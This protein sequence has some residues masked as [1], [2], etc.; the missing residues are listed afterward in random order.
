MESFL[1]ILICNLSDYHTDSIF[2]EKS[3]VLGKHAY[4]KKIGEKG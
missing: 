4:M 3:K 2:L 1:T